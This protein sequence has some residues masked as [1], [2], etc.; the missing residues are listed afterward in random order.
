MYLINERT[1]SVGSVKLHKLSKTSSRMTV[2]NVIFLAFR[3]H[4]VSM[5]TIFIDT[6]HVTPTLE[7]KFL[8]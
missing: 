2:K 5:P 7:P 3:V 8:N 1:K 4:I 6:Q